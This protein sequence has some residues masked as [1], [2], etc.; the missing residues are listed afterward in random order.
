MLVVNGIGRQGAGLI[1]RLDERSHI[2]SGIRIRWVEEHEVEGPSSTGGCL[3]E[4]A[5]ST[6][7]AAAAPRN[8]AMFPFNTPRTLP[9]TSQNTAWAAPRESASS[10]SAPEPA[11]ASSTYSPSQSM[12]LSMA[13]KSA[14][15][16][17]SVVGRVML[18]GGCLS[19][20]PRHYPANQFS[21][22]APLNNLVPLQGRGQS[23]PVIS[24]ADA[25]AGGGY[26]SFAHRAHL[27]AQGGV[28]GCGQARGPPRATRAASAWAA[29]MMAR[30]RMMFTSLRVEA[31]CWRLP[32]MSPSRRSD[33]S[34]SDS[35]KPSWMRSIAC[36]RR[37]AIGARD[38]ETRHTSPGTRRH[39]PRGHA[40]GGA[41]PSR[42]GRH[43]R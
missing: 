31:P 36:R 3:S 21:P 32:R 27:A 39:V 38:P 13:L 28:L 29:S 24:D 35:A 6:F 1:E 15:R 12:R 14:S 2:V 10:P 17:R 37:T 25:R 30:S 22:S 43:P 40:A 4:S 8:A 19:G 9:F 23:R 16:T 33:R 34:Y 42:N 11:N 20:C 5:F 18:S 26:G 41:A 7:A